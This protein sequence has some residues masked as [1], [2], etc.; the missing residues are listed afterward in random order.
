MKTNSKT[1]TNDSRKK[2]LSEAFVNSFGA[3]PIGY[4]IGILILPLSVGWL[5][6]DP[7]TANIFITM[8]YATVS[9]IRV[10]VLR[11]TFSRLGVDDNFIK[12]GIKLCQRGASKIKSKESRRNEKN[13]KTVSK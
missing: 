1:N 8:T 9:F 11:R 2:S 7:L 10:Y 13:P 3:F 5:A 12:L 4:G 6:E